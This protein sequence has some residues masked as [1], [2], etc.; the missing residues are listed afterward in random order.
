MTLTGKQTRHLRALGHHLEPIVQVG[1]NGITEAVIV[2]LAEAIDHHELVKVRLLAEC[3]VDRAEAGEE[4][5]GAT[6]AELAQTLGR[7][8]L[9]WKR[10]PQKAKV[11]LPNQR[12]KLVSPAHKEASKGKRPPSRVSKTRA[13]ASVSESPRARSGRSGAAAA[14]P[15][16]RPRRPAPAR[17]R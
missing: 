5:A 2:Q 7:T 10:N 12:G 11:E 1:K 14:R 15:S 3:P 13:E 9:F 17:A 4:L 6:G 16:A 8:L